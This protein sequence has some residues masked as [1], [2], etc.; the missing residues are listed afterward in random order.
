[1]K[2]LI[3]LSVILAFVVLANSA[4]LEEEYAAGITL[5]CKKKI[6]HDTISQEFVT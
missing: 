1:M 2:G 5:E 6:N 4:S 3:S